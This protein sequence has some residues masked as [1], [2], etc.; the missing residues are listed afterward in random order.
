MAHWSSRTRRKCIEDARA[1][2]VSLVSNLS[3]RHLLDAFLREGWIQV[4]SEE[5]QPYLLHYVSVDVEKRI[6]PFKNTLHTFGLL[7]TRFDFFECQ[8][9]A[10]RCANELVL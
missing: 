5:L 7:C 9:S 10:L 2:A 4:F 6:I 3:L 1:A 8:F